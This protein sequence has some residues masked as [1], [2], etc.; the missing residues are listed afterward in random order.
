MGFLTAQN[1]KKSCPFSQY[2][3]KVSQ[4]VSEIPTKVSDVM[5]DLVWDFF[6]VSGGQKSHPN[7][8]AFVE[9]LQ[10]EQNPT[11]IPPELL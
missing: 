7:L 6:M 4:V 8:L 10:H 11:Q 1:R 2:V 3:W 5:G 9:I